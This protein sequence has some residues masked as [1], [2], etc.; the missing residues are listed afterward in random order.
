MYEGKWILKGAQVSLGCDDLQG[1]LA[2]FDNIFDK[3]TTFCKKTKMKVNE[4]WNKRDQ[5]INHHHCATV[6]LK[7]L[8]KEEFLASYHHDEIN[9]SNIC[10]HMKKRTFKGT[11]ELNVQTFF[12]FQNWMKFQTSSDKCRHFWFK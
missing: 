2:H 10:Y 12:F 11:A 4:K 6:T 1:H 3:P 5:S 9:S 7:K 8:S